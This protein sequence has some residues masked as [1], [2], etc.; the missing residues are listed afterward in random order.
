MAFIVWNVGQELCCE[1]K[2]WDMHLQGLEVK[3]NPMSSFSGSLEGREIE[4][5]D[6]CV[7]VTLGFSNPEWRASLYGFY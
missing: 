2:S 4:P 1:L 3:C 5:C 7:C 6:P